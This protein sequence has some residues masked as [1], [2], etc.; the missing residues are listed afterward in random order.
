MA[1]QN[2]YASNALIIKDFL[3]QVLSLKYYYIVSFLIL[4]GIAFVVNR[5]SPVVVEANTVIGPIEDQRAALL[6]SNDLFRGLVSYEQARNIEN[7]INN[8]KSFTLV[9]ATLS[10]MSLEVGYFTKKSHFLDHDRQVYPD[11]PFHVSIDKSH[12]QPIDAKINFSVIDSNTYRIQIEEDEVSLYNYIDN[13][14]ISEKNVIKIDTVCKFNETVSNRYLKFVVNLTMPGVFSNRREKP[15][16]YYFVFYNLDDLARGYLENIEV[17]PVTLRSSLIN[18]S[19]KGKNISLIIDFLNTYVQTFLDDNLSKKNKMSYNAVSFID[20]QIAN[21]SDS[22]NQSESRLKDYRSANQVMDLSYQGQQAFQQMSQIE[23]DRTQL[24][25]QERYYRSILENFEKNANIAGIAPPSAANIND[26]IMN[27]LI[28][29]L[30]ALN[31]ERSNIMGNASEK[32]LFLGQIDNKIKLQNQAILENVK[33]NLNTL[34]LK[35]N[36]LD[37]RQQKLSQELSRLPRTELNMV[38]MQ[39]KFDVSGNVYTFLL[40]KRTEAAITAASNHPDYEILEPARYTTRNIISPKPMM[41]YMFALFFAL[42]LPTGYLLLK[43]F[44]NENITRVWDAEVLLKR[45]V[46]SIIYKNPMKTDAVVTEAP[47]SPIAESFRNLRS[48]LF[49]KYKNRELRTIVVTSS[50]PR[51]GKSFIS[52]NLAASIAGVGHKTIL[53]DCD[54]RRPTLHATL[55][56]KNELG[57]TNYLADNVSKE[58]II[59]ETNTENLFFIPAGPILANSSEML[60]GGSLDNLIEWLK[61]SFRYIIIDSPPM[62]IVSEATQVI[63]YASHILFVCRNNYTRKDVYTDVLNMFRTN[64][65]ENFDV[66]FNDMDIDR[67]KY[68]HYRDYYYKRAE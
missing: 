39:R 13:A 45:P 51:D 61:I 28:L 19:M 53:I 36:E 9:S 25:I 64:N 58:N 43:N 57:I 42:L 27:T 60:E 44:F 47:T 7:D 63:K 46:I 6:G 32:N 34:V 2:Q 68:G 11:P 48:R 20:R 29:D 5:Y 24:Q 30:H 38:S 12:I 14:V 26:P 62:G 33:N 18:V 23:S 52:Y 37:Y 15:H 17:K 1:N 3:A 55:N 22:L 40:Q 8:I 59:H 54:L 16:D 10:K 49:L 66:V 56:M 35:K 50:Q 21:T 65:I 31:T 4:L 67:S 41:N